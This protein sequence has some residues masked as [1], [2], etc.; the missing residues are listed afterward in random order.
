VIA[1]VAHNEDGIQ[2]VLRQLRE[3]PH[4]Q[5][6]FVLGMVGDKDVLRVLR[7]LPREAVYYFCKADI[8]RGLNAETLKQQAGKLSLNGDSYTSVHAAFQT[9]IVAAE[10]D[11]LVFVGGSIFT[12]A[13][14][15]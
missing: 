15:L 4:K 3:T 2:V 1:D 11:D 7:L 8:P 13:E 12:V 10:R 5:L 14:V 9:A 6:H